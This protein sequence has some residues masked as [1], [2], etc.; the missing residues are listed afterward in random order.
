MAKKENMGR[1]EVIVGACLISL[2]LIG[3][4]YFVGQTLYNSKVGFNT[5]DVKGL[6]EK[7][8]VSDQAY[9]IIQYTVTGNEKAGIPALYS[10]SK[11]DQ[12]QIITLL[13]DHGFTDQEIVPGVVDYSTR[14]YR[15]KDQNLIET[16]Y[17]L[18]GSIEIETKNVALVSKVR[19]K[20]NELIAEGLD[21]KNNTPNY[22]F[23]ELNAIKPDMLKEATTNARIAANEFAQNAGVKVG[24]IRSA[25][26]GGFT[27]TDVGET[28][29]DDKKIE[30]QVRV[31][32]TVTFFLTK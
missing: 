1:I 10:K 16:K 2:G 15:D 14:E 11:S 26:Q 25:S 3:G 23:T 12:Q 21:I 18:T 29:G 32:T 17:S 20:M 9:W 24:G 7:R 13:H 8:V 31:V 28:Y 22:Y 19:S 4:G 6:A 27:I 30:K 5:A